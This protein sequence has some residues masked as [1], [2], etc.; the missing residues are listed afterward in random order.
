MIN[1]TERGTNK[2]GWQINSCLQLNL[3]TRNKEL[4][5][6]KKSFFFY[7]IGSI[8]FINDNGIMYRVNKFNYIINVIFK[9]FENYQ[10]ITQKRND[11]IIFNMQR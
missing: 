1:I 7:G 11:Y 3:H 4:L 6:K 5:M 10:L 8:T 9:H 2:I